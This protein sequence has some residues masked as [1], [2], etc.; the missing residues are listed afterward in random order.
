M[1]IDGMNLWDFCIKKFGVFDIHQIPESSYD[2][3][4]VPICNAFLA[5]KSFWKTNQIFLDNLDEVYNVQNYHTYTTKC[6]KKYILT[7]HLLEAF[8][9]LNAL[10]YLENNPDVEFQLIPVCHF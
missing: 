1:K 2:D 8:N 9:T 5:K 7:A 10:T 4:R 6:P 3:L